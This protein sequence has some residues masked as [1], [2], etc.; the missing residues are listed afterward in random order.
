MS[1]TLSAPR[2]S[3]LMASNRADTAFQ[4]AVDSIL[5]QTFR[6]FE[7]ILVDDGSPNGLEAALS[8]R[9]RRDARVR[10]LRNESNRGLAASLNLA[11]GEA[12]GYYCARMDADDL[13]RPRRFALQTAFLDAHPEISVCGTA[14]C[15]H[16][17][18]RGYTYQF[19]ASD[20]EIRATLLFHTALGHPTVMW[21]RADFE[22]AGLRYDETF[23]TT[24]DY[25][26][27]S[28]A[29]GPLR[30]ANLSAVLLDYFCHAG[31]ATA[32]RYRLAYEKT[33]IICARIV[34]RLKPDATVE[35]LDFHNRLAI[36]HDPFS[37]EELDRAEAWLHS[38]VEANERMKVYLPDALRR[39][40]ARKW[41]A[42]CDVS[43][44]GIPNIVRRWSRSPLLHGQQLTREAIRFRAK[45]LLG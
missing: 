28:R 24:Q 21:R 19:P 17:E 11:M 34:R 27:W 26:L 6:D 38:L 10:I 4:R 39:V 18:G 5:T 41:T 2:V 1:F 42:I 16:I 40:I 44:S 29:L 8:D 20:P 31:Q 35:E 36:P 3:V 22:R 23:E 30:A 12:R 45:R 37:G 13:S 7:L 25:E 33:G 43:A 14:I 15:K 32:A 9:A